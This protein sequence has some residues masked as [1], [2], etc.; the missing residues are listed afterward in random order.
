[1]S[2]KLWEILVPVADNNGKKFKKKY[3]WQWDKKVVAIADGL[4]ILNPHK[5]RWVSSTGE[6]FREEMIP[7]RIACT[8]KQL[9]KIVALTAEHYSQ[10]AVMAYKISDE[11]IIGPARPKAPGSTDLR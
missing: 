1:M 4:T 10:L 5:G 9:D 6:L 2:K 3:H 11:V 7:V 8:K